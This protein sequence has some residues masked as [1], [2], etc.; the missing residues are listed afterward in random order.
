VKVTD[1]HPAGGVETQTLPIEAQVHP[2]L[3]D[4]LPAPPPDVLPAAP[5]DAP[6]EPFA[7]G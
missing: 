1:V 3:P 2:P 6:V 4:V 5:V 7:L